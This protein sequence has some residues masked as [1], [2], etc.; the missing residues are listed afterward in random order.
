M[1][2]VL[3]TLLVNSPDT[4]LAFLDRCYR[5][6]KYQ[7]R[8]LLDSPLV[9]ILDTNLDTLVILGRHIYQVVVQSDIRL[10]DTLRT[11]L[12]IRDK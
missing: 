2:V 6:H 1:E 5:D 3:D 9:G 7:D 10:A 8:G 12:E 4:N 11:N